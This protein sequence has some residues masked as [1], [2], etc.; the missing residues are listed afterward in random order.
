MSRRKLRFQDHILLLALLGSA[1]AWLVMVVLLWRWDADPALRTVLLVLVTAAA[2]GGAMA[3]RNRAVR[4][5]RALANLLQ[6]LREGDYSLRG[7]D[8]DAQDAVG[9]VMV[10]ANALSHVLREQRPHTNRHHRDR[11]AAIDC[12]HAGQQSFSRQGSRDHSGQRVLPE[13]ELAT[14]LVE[15]C[16]HGQLIGFRARTPPHQ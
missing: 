15:Y 16:M 7:Q 6:A 8:A 2:I 4:P 13:D 12:G 3:V 11:E 5:R 9:E 10:E 14:E 1:P